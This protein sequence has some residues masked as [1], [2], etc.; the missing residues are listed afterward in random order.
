MTYPTIAS[1][2]RN[3]C[4][5]FLSLVLFASALSGISQTISGQARTETGQ[6]IE[7][8]EVSLTG[9]GVSLQQFTDDNGNFSFSGV[10]TGQ[11]YELCLSLNINP[12]NGVTTFDGVVLSKHILDIELLNSP[13]KI[14]A[15]ETGTENNPPD[16]LDLYRMRQT[17]LGVYTEFPATSWKFV[18][19]DFAF[20]DPA[21]PFSYPFPLGC[22]TMTLNGNAT[23]QDFIGIKTADL[24][25]SAV[26]SN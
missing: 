19:A 26:P 11:S 1:T 7:N 2:S 20:P 5:I 6:G 9:P 14:I 12:L 10:P 17:I 22:K 18:R 15:A 4:R 21:Q 24:N 25:G 13:Y 3:R 23:N 16:V 8:V